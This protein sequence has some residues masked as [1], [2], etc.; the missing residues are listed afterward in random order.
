MKKT[1]QQTTIEIFRTDVIDSA[2]ADICTLILSH[3]FPRTHI[4]FDLEDNDN[5]LRVEGREIDTKKVIA[6]LASLEINSVLF[7]DLTAGR[8]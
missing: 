5:I 4:N 8:E 1:V 6:V 3:H 2:Q 7:E